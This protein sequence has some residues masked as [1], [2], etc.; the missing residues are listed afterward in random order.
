MK[1]L[2]QKYVEKKPKR[3]E[4]TGSKTSQKS[5]IKLAKTAPFYRTTKT[6]RWGKSPGQITCRTTG[7]ST[8]Q[9]SYFIT[10][11]VAGRLPYQPY[12]GLDLSI[13]R[14]KN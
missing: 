9:R 12:P 3:D 14:G 13:D 10:V 6:G 4:K 7:R 1:V 5:S 11:G 2:A 8:V